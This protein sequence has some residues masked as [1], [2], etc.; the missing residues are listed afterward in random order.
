MN[1]SQTNEDG[2]SAFVSFP[3]TT[4]E[5]AIPP[6]APSSDVSSIG[7]S[8]SA[9]EATLNHDRE[10]QPPP[11]PATIHSWVTNAPAFGEP[12]LHS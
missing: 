6:Q 11:D 7:P 2:L 5:S 3:R 1:V 4:H 12:F 9:S 8:R 10:E